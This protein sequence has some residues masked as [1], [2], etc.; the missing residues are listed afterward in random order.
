[1]VL[2]PQARRPLD[3]K[4]IGRLT[5]NSEVVVVAEVAELEPADA[6]Q[7]WSGLISSKQFVQYDVREVLKGEV[8][9]AKIRVGFMLLQNSLT[10]DENQPRL[11]PELF[12][13][14]NV[15]VLFLKRDLRSRAADKQRTPW[16]KWLAYDSID[17]DY[18]AVTS[19]PGLIEKIRALQ[20]KSK[21][22]IVEK[23]S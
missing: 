11:S 22:T 3:D 8:S 16:L 7:P 23:Q 21:V 1:L 2:L 9:D 5:D 12:R 17:S 13:K 19:T 18:G 14:G 20:P 10:A 6:Q 15:H 4:E